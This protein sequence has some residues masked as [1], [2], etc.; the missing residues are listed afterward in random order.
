MKK[1]NLTFSSPASCGLS[2]GEFFPMSII[3]SHKENNNNSPELSEIKEKMIQCHY[4][5]IVIN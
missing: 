2:V 3:S 4:A 5:L 1:V